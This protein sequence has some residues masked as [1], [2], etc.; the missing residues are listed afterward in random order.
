MAER[1]QAKIAEKLAQKRAQVEE[2]T[3]VLRERIQAL[4]ADIE[5]LAERIAEAERARDEIKEDARPGQKA[6]TEAR[7]ERLLIRREHLEMKQELLQD[8]IEM[9][10]EQLA[11]LERQWQ[12]KVADA[13]D[14]PEKT[15]SDERRKILEMVAKGQISAE[16]AEELLSALGKRE[17]ASV[18]PGRGPASIVRIRITDVTTK[19]KHLDIRLPLNFMRRAL[20]SGASLIP[21]LDVAGLSFDTQELQEL[22]QSGETGHLV[23]IM[24]DDEHIEIIVE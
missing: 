10:A 24:D 14:T 17:S 15:A 11:E 22:L 9:L 16:E 5:S 4:T 20:R 3:A 21:N 19:Q 2:K 8:R 1:I 6:R 23:D 12:E 7:L 13:E 18:Q